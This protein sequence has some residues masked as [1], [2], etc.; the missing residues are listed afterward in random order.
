M[1]RMLALFVAVAITVPATAQHHTSNWVPRNGTDSTHVVCLD[2]SLTWMQFPPGAMAG[3]MGMMYDSVFTRIDWMPMDSLDHPHDSTVIGW[4]RMRVGGDSTTFD[5]MHDDDSHLGHHGM[6]YTL[7]IL[8]QIHWDS[9]RA[10]SLHRSW[11][12]TGL[13]GWD[14]SAWV[15]IPSAPGEGNTLVTESSALY[16]ATAIVGVPGTVTSVALNPA[17]ELFMLYQNFPNPFNPTTTIQ[18]TLPEQSFVRLS[19]VNSVGEE[20]ATLVDGVQHAG[21]HAVVFDASGLASG[22]YLYRL[23]ANGGSQVRKTLLLR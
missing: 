20:I 14:G 16:A 8:C 12:P 6:Q 2:D 3:M 1:L 9:L 19:V 13:M 5:L 11:R 17:P 22:V 10:D 21:L 4:Y 23:Q 18:Y 7:D 15:G